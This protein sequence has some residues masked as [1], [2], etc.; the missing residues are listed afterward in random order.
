LGTWYLSGSGDLTIKQWNFTTEC[1]NWIISQ[2]F[3]SCQWT[4]FAEEYRSVLHCTWSWSTQQFFYYLWWQYAGTCESWLSID[5]ERN[6]W[7]IQIWWKISQRKRTERWRNKKQAKKNI[8][9]KAIHFC[10]K[11]R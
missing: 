5:S 1:W 11:T 4:S 9:F 3:F 6:F 8:F 7:T 2:S 10:L